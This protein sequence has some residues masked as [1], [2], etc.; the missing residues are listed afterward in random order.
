MTMEQ[1]DE[2]SLR[3]FIELGELVG[4]TLDQGGKL[5]EA[6]KR[7]YR[8]VAGDASVFAV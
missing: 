6:A 7:I 1:V 3:I 2:I 4:A 8:D 5:S